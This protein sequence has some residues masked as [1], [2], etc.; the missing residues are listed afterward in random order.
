M[1]D[2]I[3]GDIILVIL[4]SLVVSFGLW[5]IV[6]IFV[7]YWNNILVDAISI[8][9][10]ISFWDGFWLS[11]FGIGIFGTKYIKRSDD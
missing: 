11:M 6:S 1:S 7:M 5:V 4:A 3:L 10:P 2:S 9:R 8:F